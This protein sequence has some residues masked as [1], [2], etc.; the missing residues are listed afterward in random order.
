MPRPFGRRPALI[1]TRSRVIPHLRA[2]TVAPI[3]QTIREIES[4]V[5]LSPEIGVPKPCAVSLD[6]I[7]T[8]AK[9]RIDMRIVRVPADVMEEIFEAIRFTFDM[10]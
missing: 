1:L 4:E 8:I 5:I 9:S 6:N 2:V 7:F 10:P 3:T